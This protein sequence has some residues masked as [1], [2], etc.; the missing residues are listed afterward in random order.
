MKAS[1]LRS[2]SNDELNKELIALLKELFNLRMQKGTGQAPKSHL[3]KKVKLGI[4]RIKT[5]LQ[6]KGTSA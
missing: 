2:K 1:E 3:F 4:A 5:I 6:E